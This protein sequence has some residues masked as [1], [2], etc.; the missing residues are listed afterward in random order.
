MEKEIFK[1]PLLHRPGAISVLDSNGHKVFDWLTDN[2]ELREKIL[3][4]INNKTRE[5]LGISIYNRYKQI[6]TLNY[7]PILRIRGWG[8]LTGTGGLCLSVEE[9]TTVQDN[10]GINIA[11]SIG[12]EKVL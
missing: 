11:N 4:V 12:E 5:N 2:H 6:V 10:L 3:E 9:A 8:Y 7:R 1:L